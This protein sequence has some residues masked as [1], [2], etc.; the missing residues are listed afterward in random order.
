MDKRNYIVSN[1][2]IL[3]TGFKPMYS[4]DYGIQELIKVYNIL[5]KNYTKE[6]LRRIP[7]R[8]I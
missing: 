3:S 5:L 7:F 4:I 2:R 8:N 6:E 1:K